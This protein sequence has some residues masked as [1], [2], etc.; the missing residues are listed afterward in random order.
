MRDRD[1][2]FAPWSMKTSI[3]CKSDCLEACFKATDINAAYCI[4][5]LSAGVLLKAT[6][7]RATYVLIRSVKTNKALLLAQK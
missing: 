6:L 3:R 7:G 2:G 4:Y 5:E 1:I